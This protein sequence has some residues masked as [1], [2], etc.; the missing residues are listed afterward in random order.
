MLHLGTGCQAFVAQL[1]D[2]HGHLVVIRCPREIKCL[3]WDGCGSESGLRKRY[4]Q[5]GQHQ[6]ASMV[7]DLSKGVVLPLWFLIKTDTTRPRITLESANC[8]RCFWSCVY[9]P[10]L[11]EWLQSMVPHCTRKVQS[12]NASPNLLVLGAWGKVKFHW[13]SA[14]KV[15]CLQMVVDL[16]CSCLQFSACGV[17]SVNGSWT[18]PSSVV[19]FQRSRGAKSTFC[20]WPSIQVK[21]EANGRTRG[22]LLLEYVYLISCYLQT[23]TVFYLVVGRGRLWAMDIMPFFMR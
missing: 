17:I 8:R 4:Q 6:S 13:N 16:S 2:L 7:I 21:G 22:T 12:F 1:P 5:Y 3:W 23:F 11:G 9:W 10:R 18:V 14:F 20:C 19:F 15:A